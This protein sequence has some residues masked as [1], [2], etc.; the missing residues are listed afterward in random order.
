MALVPVLQS[1]NPELVERRGDLSVYRID[2]DARLMGRP[3]FLHGGAIGALFDAALSLKIGE[4]LSGQDVQAQVL[5][6]GIEYLRGGALAETWVE[7]S[8]VRAGF[9]IVNLAAT[10]W[11]DSRDRPIANC[12]MM[13]KV[14]RAKPA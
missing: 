11:Q 8:L 9:R 7:V 13:F 6:M 10:A 12:R 1:I 5:D 14:E 3:G 2:V 4:V